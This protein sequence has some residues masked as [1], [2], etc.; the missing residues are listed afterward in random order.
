MAAEERGGTA[1]HCGDLGSWVMN[2]GHVIPHLD[3]GVNVLADQRGWD[4]RDVQTAEI[5]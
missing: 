5:G 3:S 1:W 2:S 4:A